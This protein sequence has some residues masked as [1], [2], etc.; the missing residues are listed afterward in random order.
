MTQACEWKSNLFVPKSNDIHFA[1]APGSA[2]GASEPPAGRW[3]ADGPGE[4]PPRQPQSRTI[5][6]STQ[7]ALILALPIELGANFA[8]YEPGE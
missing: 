6:S 7:K 1:Q 5:F 2:P 8:G 3:R 4:Q